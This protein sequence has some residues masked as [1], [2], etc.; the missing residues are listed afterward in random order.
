MH[1]QTISYFRQFST[2][3]IGGATAVAADAS[4]IHHNIQ[5]LVMI[6]NFR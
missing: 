6:E 2:P 5:E 3:G 1:G 4:G